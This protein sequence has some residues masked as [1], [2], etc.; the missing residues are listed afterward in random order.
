MKATRSVLLLGCVIAF[1]QPALAGDKRPGSLSTRTL[2][3]GDK[4]DNTKIQTLM[5]GYGRANVLR[6]SIQK[7]KDD[8][9]GAVIGKI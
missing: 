6:S 8:T 4:L 9:A 3:S 1:S 2:A 7:K 5:S